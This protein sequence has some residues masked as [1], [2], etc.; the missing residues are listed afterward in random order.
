MPYDALRSPKNT[1]ECPK[2]T[3]DAA[4]NNCANSHDLTSWH[5]RLDIRGKDQ[6]IVGHHRA[7]QGS[8]E[9]FEMFKTFMAMVPM[10]VHR[11]AISAQSQ[12]NHIAI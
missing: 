11:G 8:P 10:S 3:D 9:C 12:G 2:N 4:T 6:G 5:I 7:S 1:Q